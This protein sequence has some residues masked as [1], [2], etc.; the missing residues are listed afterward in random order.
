MNCGASTACYYPQLL[1]KTIEEFY[2]MGIQNLE[3]FL[4]TYSEVE[5]GYVK[6]MAKRIKNNGQKVIAVHPFSCAFEPFMFFTNYER[7]FLDALEWYKQYFQAMNLLG[8]SVFIFHGDRKLGVMEDQQYY[9]RFARLRDVGKA[10]G[11]TVAQENVVHCKS[12]SI[13]FLQN[14]TEYLDEDVALV[15]DNKQAIRSQI[16]YHE[17]V[18]QL[19]KYIVHVHL[20][21]NDDMHDCLPIGEGTL[22]IKAFLSMFQKLHYEGYFIEE[23]YSSSIQSAKHFYDSYKKLEEISAQI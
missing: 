6:E 20:S 13:D 22:D 15:F 19:G 12:G 11:I 7:R 23:I 2:Q 10:F 1:E 16:N 17:F 4:N 8:A 9:E 18:N 21:D 3:I 5:T 14:M